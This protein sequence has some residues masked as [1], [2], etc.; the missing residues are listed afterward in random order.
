MQ[1]ETSGRFGEEIESEKR[2]GA[3]QPSR[4]AEAVHCI[5]WNRWCVSTNFKYEIGT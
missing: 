5:V 4:R 1:G 2:R 3:Q